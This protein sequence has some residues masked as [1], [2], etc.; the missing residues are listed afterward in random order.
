MRAAGPRRGL[1]KLVKE[2]RKT[3]GRCWR[4]KENLR[5]G[6]EEKPNLIFGVERGFFFFFLHPPSKVKSVSIMP[7]PLDK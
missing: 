5:E 6:E 3:W 1:A 2:S 7:P 4:E